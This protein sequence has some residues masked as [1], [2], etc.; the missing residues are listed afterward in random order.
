MITRRAAGLEH[1]FPFTHWASLKDKRWQCALEKTRAMHDEKAVSI[2][3]SEFDTGILKRSNY[4][5]I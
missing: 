4:L 2:F 1:V 5:L 3:A